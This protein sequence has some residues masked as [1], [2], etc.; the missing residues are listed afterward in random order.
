M[1]KINTDGAFRAV[2]NQ[3]GWGFVVRNRV[4][5]FLE[6]G[7]GNLRR[8]ASSFQAEALAV[9]HSVVRVS[10]LGISRIILETDASDLVRGLTSTDLDQSVDGSLLKQTQGFHLFIF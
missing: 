9:L 1:Y 7:C 6:G 8:V 5:D 2:T 4:G 10:Q 3:G